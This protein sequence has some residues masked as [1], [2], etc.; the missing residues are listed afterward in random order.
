M[1]RFEKEHIIPFGLDG[2]LV[3]PNASCDQCSA[4]T[5]KFEQTCLRTML[6]PARIRLGLRTRRPKSRPKELYHRIIHPSGRLMQKLVPIEKH[7][8]CLWA[9]ELPPAGILE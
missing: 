6:G 2:N 3:L 9:Y 1:L 7:P 4:I 8:L 5:A